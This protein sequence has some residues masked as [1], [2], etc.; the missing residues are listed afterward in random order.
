MRVE[1]RSASSIVCPPDVTLNCDMDY[2]DENMIGSASLYNI[3]ETETISVSFTPQ[4]NACGE[5]FVIAT[6]S[7]E[8]SSPT[9]SCSQR[10]T[11]ENQD[12]AF[13]PS[14][15]RFPRNLPTSPTGQISCT[16]DITYDA[17]T[18]TAGPCDFIGYTEEVDTFFIENGSGGN[19]ACFRIL[20]RF[21]VIDW[22]VYDETNGE[23]GLYIG[24]QTI[25]ITDNEAPLLMDCEPSIYDV[26]ADCVRAS[27]VLTNMAEDN[28][29]CAS[30]WLK[31]QVFVDTWADGV[32]DYEYS[33]FLPSNDSN[34]NNDTNGNGINDRYLAPTSSGE[35]VAVDVTEVL[36]SSMTNH[37]VTWKVTDGCGNV[38]SCTTTFMVV[39]QK[40]P[41]PYCINVYTALMADPDGDGPLSPMVELWAKDFDKGAFDNCTEQED[42][43]FTFG[44]SFPVL[45]LIDEAHY[46]KGEGQLATEAEY[47][48]GNAQYWDP[49]E[50]T[51]GMV[52]DCDDRPSV[53]IEIRVTD[54]KGNSD[55][56]LIFLGIIDNQDGCDN[57]GSKADIAGN[58]STST[59]EFVQGIEVILGALLPE[60]PRSTEVVDGTFAFSD[61]DLFIDYDVTA[62]LNDNPSNGVSTLDLVL[63]QRHIVG[64]SELD[65]PYKVIAADISNDEKLSALDII[66]LR[67]VIL[68]VQDEFNSVDSWRFVD[69]AQE[70]ADVVSPWPVDYSVD[71]DNLE[72]NINSAN[73]VAVKMG[74]VNDTYTSFTNQSTDVRSGKSVSLSVV[75]AEL[76]SNT[77]GIIEITNDE[78]V[79]T[80]GLQMSIEF[81]KVTP[82]T[83]ESSLAGFGDANYSINGNLVTISWSANT[84]KTVDAGQ[85]LFTIICN[86][87]SNIAISDVITISDRKLRSEVYLGESHDINNV[88]LVVRDGNGSEVELT[89][90]VL[91]QNE[92]NPFTNETT[93][94]Y[95]LKNMETSATI[96]VMD[97]MG[98]VIYS[99]SVNA[100]KGW[101]THSISQSDLAA[102]GVY[103]YQ[104]DAG[105]FSEIKSMILVK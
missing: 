101:N 44:D 84:L 70:F 10:I 92:P 103:Y 58:I 3:C 74:D 91:L 32:V 9:N 99:Q 53:N 36:E 97:V 30:D 78:K 94:S 2:T 96:K 55:T 14:G 61:N 34:I 63:I 50:Q 85:V 68:G 27:T 33:S 29:D 15:I 100:N 93:I 37:I 25:K 81:N 42:L 57:A 89:S 1:G 12:D 41:T 49:V 59:G 38:S 104:L 16:D 48:A 28:G 69:A 40:A 87:E 35:E 7:I 23:E 76:V 95:Y 64:L 86:V 4:L 8:G 102:S 82:I 39:D 46:F 71:I 77:V 75:D 67:K 73:M 56:C 21:T 51:A 22:C 17:P 66:E 24:S 54:E 13:D 47:L 83:I 90:K 19:N 65:S 98:K 6:Y 88:E 45:A 31:W 52:F 62:A 105:N 20:R 26:D 43:L 80:Q 5:G 60:Y 79:T 72:S 11:M 18:W